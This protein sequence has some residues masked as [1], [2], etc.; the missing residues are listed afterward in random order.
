MDQS[1]PD[2]LDLDQYN[3]HIYSTVYVNDYTT[4]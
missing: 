1:L 4:Q 3:Q 2:M